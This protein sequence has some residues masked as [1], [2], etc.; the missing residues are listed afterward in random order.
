MPTDLLDPALLVALAVGVLG[1]VVFVRLRASPRAP[2]CA[3][4]NLPMVRDEDILDAENP[5]LRH[6]E[7]YRQAWFT[8]RQCGTRKRGT[9]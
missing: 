5:E 7:G 2:R 9:Y 3:E 1:V 4:C 8:C 6:V